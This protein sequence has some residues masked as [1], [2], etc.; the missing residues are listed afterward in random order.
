M[1][2]LSCDV[3]D[4]RVIEPTPH[5]DARGRFMRAWCEREFSD[6]GIAFTP[7]QSNMGYSIRAGTIRGMHYQVAPALEA[8]LVRCTRGAIFDVGV[9][10]RPGSPTFRDWFGAELTPDND[11]LLYLPV[12]VAHGFQTLAARS[13]VAYWMSAPYVPGAERGVRWDDPAFGIVWPDPP[14]SG[15]VMSERDASYPS[16]EAS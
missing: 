11:T 4:A 12:G 9:D 8:K 7:L 10:L 13:E 5:A 1:K 14:K 16:F 15:R 2:F 6:A 3:A